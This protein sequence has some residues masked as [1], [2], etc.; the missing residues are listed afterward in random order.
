V[1]ATGG[2]VPSILYVNESGTLL[3]E[4]AD[5]GADVLSIDWRVRPETARAVAV[6]LGLG[7]QG[8]LDP[9]ALFAPPEMVRRLTRTMLTR[10]GGA[11]G[12]IVNLGSGILP[13]TPVE[14]ACAFVDEVRSFKSAGLP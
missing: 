6:P 1:A 8:N 4:M 12:Y 13:G 9:T 3:G 10:F 11:P 7:L 14:S 2:R 5:T